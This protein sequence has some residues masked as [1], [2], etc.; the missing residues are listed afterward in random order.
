MDG[1]KV[2]LDELT[3]GAGSRSQEQAADDN[4]RQGPDEMRRRGWEDRR[5]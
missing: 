4:R 2:E 3:H 1:I 5:F